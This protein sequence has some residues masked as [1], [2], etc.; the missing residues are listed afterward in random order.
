MDTPFDTVIQDI[1][2]AWEKDHPQTVKNLFKEASTTYLKAHDYE[3]HLRLLLACLSIPVLEEDLLRN[4]EEGLRQVEEVSDKTFAALYNMV[5]AMLCPYNEQEKRKA[6]AAK[7]LSDPAHLATVRTDDYPWLVK[8]GEDSHL[9]GRDLLSFIGMETESW[10]TLYEYYK[11]TDKRGAACYTAV[12]AIVHSESDDAD[13]YTRLMDVLREYDDQPEVCEAVDAIMT[14]NLLPL[15]EGEGLEADNARQEAKYHF[16]KPYVDRWAGYPHLGRLHNRLEDLQSHLIRIS[17][18]EKEIPHRPITL[19]VTRKNATRLTLSIYTTNLTGGEKIDFTDYKKKQKIVRKYTK[20]LP[21]YSKT[22][23]YAA[24][25]PYLT[26]EETLT[27]DGLAHGIYLVTIESEHGKGNPQLLYVSGLTTLTE[28]LPRQ[29][30]RIVVV[31]PLTGHPMPYAHAALYKSHEDKSPFVRVRC[32][33][34]GEAIYNYK[35]YNKRPSVIYPYTESDRYCKRE[36]IDNFWGYRYD[37]E[38]AKETV[39]LLTDRA[40]YRPGQMVHVALVSYRVNEHKRVMVQSRHIE[41]ELAKPYKEPFAHKQLVT[42]T[43]GVAHCDFVL[44]DDIETGVYQLRC[45]SN[46]RQLRIEAYKRP[47]FEVKIDDYAG[48]YRDGDTILLEGSATSYTGEPVSQA[49]VRYRVKRATAWWWRF[50]APYWETEGHYGRYGEDQYH[51]GEATTD[52][53]GHFKIEVPLR[54]S[55]NGKVGRKPLFVNIVT[56][57]DVTDSTGESQNARTELPLSNKQYVLR[58][59]MGEKIERQESL[60]FTALLK[61]A[62]GQDLAGSITWH[63]DGGEEHTAPANQSVEIGPTGIGAHTLKVSYGEDE[64]EHTFVVFDKDSTTVPYSTP[65]WAYQSANEFPE[66]GGEVILQI[67]CADADTYILY[68]LFSGNKLLESGAEKVSTGMINRRLRYDKAYGGGILVSYAWIRN[69]EMQT[70]NFTIKKALPDRKLQITWKTFRDRVTP[71]TEEEWTLQVKD[72]AGRNVTA[73]VI[74][75]LYDKSLEQLTTDT[76]WQNF[77]PRL[78]W[79]VPHTDWEHETLRSNDL[80]VHHIEHHKEREYQFYEIVQTLIEGARYRRRYFS[81]NSSH[82]ISGEEVCYDAPMEEREMLCMSGSSVCYSRSV[83]AD[84]APLGAPPALDEAADTDALPQLR[85]DMSETAFFLPQLATDSDGEVSIVFTVPD[86]LTTWRF[87]ALA[88]TRDLRYAYFD[89]ETIARKPVMVQSHLPRFVRV[90]DATTLTAKVSN[91]TE[92][93]ISGR[94]QIELL[95]ARDERVVYSER[96]AF[97]LG[98]GGSMATSFTFTSDE[99]VKDYLCRLYAV[100]DGFSDGEQHSLPVLTDK[101]EVTVT[102]VLNHDGACKEEVDTARLLPAGSSRHAL[103]LQYTNRPIWLAIKA[104]PPLQKPDTDNA[105]SLSVA[106]F[107][108]HLTTYLQNIAARYGDLSPTDTDALAV[109]KRKIVR[110]LK[111]LQGSGGGFRWYEK[112]PESLYMTTEVLMHL[113]R[114]QVMTGPVEELASLTERAFRFCDAAM[115]EEIRELRKREAKGDEVYLPTFTLL[116]HLYNCAITHRELDSKTLDAY[117]YLVALLEKDIHRQTIR[118]KAMSAVILDYAGYHGRAQDYAESLRQYTACDAERGRTFDTPRATYSWYSYKIPTHVAGMEALHL[119]CPDDRDTYRE[120][121]KWLLQEK[122]TQT[123]ETPI[124]SVNAV[125]A[126]LLDGL[127]ELAS[128]GTATFTIDGKPLV[129][130]TEGNEGYVEAALPATT[131]TLTVEKTS[132]GLSWGAVYATFLQPISEVE[133]SGSGMSIHREILADTENLHVGE[134]IRVRLTYTCDRD[135]DMV[136]VTDS[137]AA[138]MEPVQQ[139]S[140][141]D[142]FKRVQPLDTEVR[143]FY[144][145]LAEGTYSIETEYYLDRAGVYETGLAT[146]VCEYAPEFRAVCPSVRLV[147]KE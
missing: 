140:W 27:T 99:E 57:V 20:Q 11:T 109:S 90:G 9:F 3:R 1:E 74:A 116:Q 5:A 18:N 107:C 48:S 50:W 80:S 56:E 124:D 15:P 63:L 121:Q 36:S 73:N 137:K 52:D 76:S 24:G 60:T 92:G 103:S 68:N 8:H 93:A 59:E 142:S 69:Q 22:Y 38:E 23:E 41:V 110:K 25:K 30:I 87:K 37:G 104:L 43:M 42:D 133:A 139:L 146:I 39:E 10:E 134:R 84:A 26:Y 7:A 113:S 114:L 95:D 54:L 4:T 101:A 89:A 145:G 71:G 129:L 79:Q 136:R 58:L 86:S 13:R 2:T 46:S 34:K 17:V 85:T 96:R 12:Q 66:D 135:F 125:Y 117:Q 88:H 115:C 55:N 53:E 105:I 122:R 29:K 82:R 128:K 77:G 35:T 72:P 98:A 14:N 83:E 94:V 106:L 119:L 75:T 123:W 91:T 6:Y 31:D 64:A 45:G 102:H 108:N 126:L 100:G 70:H 112:M 62:L 47:T 61:N 127:E 67:G 131:R 81:L 65:C 49:T 118:E 143:I 32:D 130:D 141:G 120:M 19:T 111:K 28:Y 51:D 21:H 40:I 132:P 138:C 97:T 16:L 33:E 44:P 144:Y 147:V 78:S